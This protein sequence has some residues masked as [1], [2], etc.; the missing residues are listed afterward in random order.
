L[1][2]SQGDDDRYKPSEFAPPKQARPRSGD[3]SE[4]AMSHQLLENQKKHRDAKRSQA[5][6]ISPQGLKFFGFNHAW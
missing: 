1:S 5:W 6:P 3:H 4:P 2:P